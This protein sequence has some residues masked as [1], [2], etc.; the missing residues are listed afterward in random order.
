MFKGVKIK[1]ILMKK[2]LKTDI[3]MYFT[4]LYNIVNNDCYKIF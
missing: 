1:M 3:V 4:A 2:I